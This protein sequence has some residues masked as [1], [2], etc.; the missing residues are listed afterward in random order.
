MITLD[1][2]G[3]PQLQ[4]RAAAAQERADQGALAA[5][6]ARGA[7]SGV[8][9][10]ALRLGASVYDGACARCHDVG[11][12]VSSNGALRLPIAVAV[13]DPDPRSL[14]RIVREGIVPP[15]LSSGRWMPAFG[16]TLTDDQLVALLTW[17]RATA[18]AAPPWPDLRQAVLDSKGKP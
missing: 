18:A 2:N 13:Y 15:P 9:P 6:P 5:L 14:L 1:V 4:A 17:L 7:A 12:N 11:R 8:D 3:A 16:S 10:A